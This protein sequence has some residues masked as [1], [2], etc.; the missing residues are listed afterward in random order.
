MSGTATCGV[1]ALAG[2]II[3]SMCSYV[4]AVDTWCARETARTSRPDPRAIV[5]FDRISRRLQAIAADESGGPLSADK[6]DS[7][8]AEPPGAL[9][10]DLEHSLGDAVLGG[11][12]VGEYFW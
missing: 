11:P 4:A 9:P 5:I 1:M 2:T 12:G 8:S 3:T 7:L 10:N 6:H